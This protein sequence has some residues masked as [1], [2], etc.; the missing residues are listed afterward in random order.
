MEQ[1]KDALRLTDERVQSICHRLGFSSQSYFGKQ[2]K[3]ATGMTPGEYREKQGRD[4]N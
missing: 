1:A 2:F 4:T 3:E